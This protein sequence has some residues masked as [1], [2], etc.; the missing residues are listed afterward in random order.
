MFLMCKVVTHV[1]VLA[2]LDYFLAGVKSMEDQ[3]L[4]ISVKGL[5]AFTGPTSLFALAFVLGGGEK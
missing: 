1:G 5:I 4:H 2:L 3:W